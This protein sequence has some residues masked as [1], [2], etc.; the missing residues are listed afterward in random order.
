MNV[1]IKKKQ[2]QP[3]IHEG[4]TARIIEQRGGVSD[5]CELN[6]QIKADNILLRKLKELVHS[7]ENTATKIAKKLENPQQSNYTKI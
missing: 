3:T 5:R 7:L 1:Y 2:K 4:V 6:R